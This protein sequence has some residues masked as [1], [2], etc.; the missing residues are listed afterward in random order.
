MIKVVREAGEE[1]YILE[2][3]LPQWESWGWKREGE[4]PARQTRKPAADKAE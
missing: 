4:A 3:W 2:D 1:A